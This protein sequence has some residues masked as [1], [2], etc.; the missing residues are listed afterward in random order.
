MERLSWETRFDYLL[1]VVT[2]ALFIAVLLGLVN[3]DGR[4]FITHLPLNDQSKVLV[5]IPFG[6]VVPVAVYAIMAVLREDPR[7]SFGFF[8]TVTVISFI[9]VGYKSPPTITVDNDMRTL[10][11]LLRLFFYALLGLIGAAILFWL[12]QRLRLLHDYLSRNL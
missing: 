5:I 8:V 10:Y 6:I 3:V 4:R 9:I 12:L 2:L 11:E 7:R 1:T